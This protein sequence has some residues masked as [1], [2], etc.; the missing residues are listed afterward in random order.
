MVM[1]KAPTVAAYLA[2]QAPE[3]RAE[4]EKV[5]RVLRKQMPKGYREG[6]AWGMI[7]WEIP[8]ERYPDTY[9]R[10]PLCYAG[11]AVQKNYLTLYLMGVYADPA[12]SAR[13]TRAFRDAGL[14]LDMGKSCIHF[15]RAEDLPLEAIGELVAG[16][17]VEEYIRRYESARTPAARRTAKKSAKKVAKP[18][19]TPRTR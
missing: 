3:R 5:L 1:S 11:L 10:Q 4:L 19:A 14:R 17:P 18:A 12:R 8:L 7:G 2:E 6:M 16:L 9:N 15:R 13:L